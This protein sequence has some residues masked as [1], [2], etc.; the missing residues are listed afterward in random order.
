MECQSYEGEC[1]PYPLHGPIVRRDRP[2]IAFPP[3]GAPGDCISAAGLARRLHF[4]RNAQ[5]ANLDWPGPSR[6]RPRYRTIGEFTISN[7]IYHNV[8]NLNETHKYL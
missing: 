8:L 1:T 2:A 6:P 5:G 4:R 7:L 3:P